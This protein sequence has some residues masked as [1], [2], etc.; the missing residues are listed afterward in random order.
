MIQLGNTYRDY[1]HIAQE[2]YEM[3]ETYFN[4]TDRYRQMIL[5]LWGDTKLGVPNVDKVIGMS[6]LMDFRK[7]LAEY[8][9]ANEEDLGE[10]A[11]SYKEQIKG[12]EALNNL[13]YTIFAKL[14]ENFRAY[15]A[16][17]LVKPIKQG[18][19]KVA[20]HF[21]KRLNIR[22]CPYCNRQYTFTISSTTTNTSPEYDHFY[23]KS[24]YPILAVSFYNLVPSCHTCNH[25]KGTQKIT[26]NPYFHRM[27]GRF[28]VVDPK[29]EK[30][31]KTD[32][33][34][35]KKGD[36]KLDWLPDSEEA[37]N[38]KV[39]GLRELY[40]QHDD[41]VDEIISKT[42]AYNKCA[43]ELLADGFQNSGYTENDVSNFVWGPYIDVANH[44]KR[45]LSKLTFDL[46]RQF[47]VI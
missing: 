28:A 36:W 7:H 32:V 23:D 2:W 29:E 4:R 1:A 12:H 34:M 22:T 5:M 33:M 47:G 10:I 35:L 25:L 46:L 45:P 11:E 21:F 13:L 26:V 44:G 24:E 37:Q 18:K 8:V 39:F 30:N 42:Q 41:Y 31:E 20:Y 15:N 6:V 38:V 16:N 17:R 3:V 40:A 19:E 43:R 14:Y 27:E 9:L